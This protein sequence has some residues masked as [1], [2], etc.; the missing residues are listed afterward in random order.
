MADKLISVLDALTNKKLVDQGDGSWAE[1]VAIASVRTTVTATIPNGGSV[2]PTVDLASACLLAFI[3]P[4]AWSAAALNIEV[5]MTGG[6]SASEWATAGLFDAS[7][8]ATGQYASLTGGAAYAVDFN[9][10]LGYR[11]VRLRSGTAAS[12]VN[13]GA[14]RDFVLITRPLA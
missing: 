8:V 1:A 2:T 12:P 5:S 14:Q 4:A 3:A 10:L 11:Y 9:S 13:Q 6:A 7:G